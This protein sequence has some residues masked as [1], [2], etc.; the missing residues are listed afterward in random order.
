MARYN[1]DGSSALAPNDPYNDMEGAEIRPD[2]G[3][4]NGGKTSKSQ[5]TSNRSNFKVLDGG[6]SN[7]SKELLRNSENSALKGEPTF[8]SGWRNNVSGLGK[9]QNDKNSKKGGISLNG[10]KKGI[11]AS[12]VIIGI[13]VT[14]MAFLGGSNALLMPATSYHATTQILNASAWPINS[15]RRLEFLDSL[16]DASR[17]SKAFSAITGIPNWLKTR[18]ST[19]K[20][21]TVNG[22]SVSWNGQN[23][24]GNFSQ[25]YK[26][27][28]EFRSDFDNTAYGRIISLQDNTNVNMFNSKFGITGN[29]YADYKQTGDA[30]TDNTNYRQISGEMFD[31]KTSTTL[32]TGYE[33]EVEQLDE[34][35]NGTGVYDLEDR[36]TSATTRTTNQAVNAETI[37]AANDYIQGI[38]QKVGKV[39]NYSCTVLRAATMVATAISGVATYNYARNAISNYLEPM[40]KTMA[41]DGNEAPINAVLN[42]MTT[43]YTTKVDNL[44]DLK[45]TGSTGDAVDCSDNCNT[46]GNLSIEGINSADDV[47]TK[48]YTGAFTED[49]NYVA[50]MTGTQYNKQDAAINSFNR[51]L[52]AV[53]TSLKTFNITNAICAAAQGAIAGIELATTVV[54]IGISLLPGGQVVAGGGVVWQ[55][56]RKLFANIGIGIVLNFAVSSF[57]AFLVPQLAKT[58]FSTPDQDS[59][60]IPG[61]ENF[62]QALG[63]LGGQTS[64]RNNGGDIATIDEAIAYSKL[65]QEVIA[66]EAEVDRM[67][68]SPFDITSSNT[69][70]GSIMNSL[71]PTTFTNGIAPIQTIMNATSTAIANVTNSASADGENS[72]YLNTFGNCE[73][74]KDTY[75]ENVAAD[76]YCNPIILNDTSTLDTPIDDPK[77]SQVIDDALECD[78]DGKNCSVKSDSNLARYISYCADR[79][80]P[81]GVVDANILS[82]L[83]TGSVVLNALP[84]VGNVVDILNASN[85]A[86]HEAWASGQMCSS[87]KNPNWEDEYKYYQLYMLDMHIAEQIGAFENSEETGYINPITAYRE[88]YAAEH[89][90]DDSFAGYIARVSGVTKED[91]E[92]L[93]AVAQYYLYLQEYDPGSRIALDNTATSIKNGEEVIVEYT[94]KSIILENQDEII[95]EYPALKNN[96]YIIYN[97]TRNRNFVA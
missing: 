13:I 9:P 68:R 65:N 42:R 50:M 64:R 28:A 35:G 97:D 44:T 3:V 32:S 6:K 89:P 24:S 75:G 82:E 62:V 23:V 71:L 48:E 5:N 78:S 7:A 27:D 92:G 31:N 43:P 18:F 40:S 67:H 49:K 59:E 53:I 87:T 36:Q 73:Y 77:Y 69:F 76:I 93:I 83:E 54:G 11:A 85:Y 20:N 55:G 25:L 26:T 96:Q 57:M 15:N 17:S 72:T 30:V 8:N 39:V 38:T 37:K 56:I 52:Q 46:Q 33:E 51:S 41:G 14:I 95:T 60:G 4:I 45:I 79:P 22:D 1:T 2:F 94:S 70:L 47:P 16:G 19:N 91:A 10:K 86:K 84:V 66:M 21:F 90:E 58:L 34:D 74:L 81:F 29:A 61:A 63:I 88:K 12:G 80:S